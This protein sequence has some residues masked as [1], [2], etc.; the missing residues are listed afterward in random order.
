[1]IAEV[2]KTIRIEEL[3]SEKEKIR[4]FASK[5]LK[6]MDDN[7]ESR[8]SSD[9][10]LARPIVVQLWTG[11]DE[12]EAAEL[13]ILLNHS[14]QRVSNRHLVEVS[15]SEMRQIFVDWG[16][17]ISTLRNEKEHPG[18]RGKRS[19]AEKLHIQNL[20]KHTLI[21]LTISSMEQLLMPHV[22]NTLKHQLH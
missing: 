17:P 9:E 18:H 4:K 8:L 2:L 3:G 15:R 20:R 13:F 19:N 1:M 10:F 14:Q 7:G 22:I 5:K 11:I 12:D 6:E 21:G 16:L